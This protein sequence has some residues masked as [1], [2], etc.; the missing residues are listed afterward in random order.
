MV[1][2][3]PALR[4]VRRHAVATPVL[5][6]VEG[7]L[8]W[9]RFRGFRS[10]ELAAAPA[11]GTGARA[12]CRV[13]TGIRFRP[14][15]EPGLTVDY[16]LRVNLAHS[17]WSR[18]VSITWPPARTTAATR[19]EL[20]VAVNNA[21]GAGADSIF[22][23]IG[24]S[25]ERLDIGTGSGMSYVRAAV[26]NGMHVLP[27]FTAGEGGSLEGLTPTEVASDIASLVP[28]LTRLG[29]ATLEFGNEVYRFMDARSY[30]A[31]YDAAHRVVAGRIKLLAPATTGWYEHARGGKGSWFSDL[32]AALP[33]G[34]G[35]VD[36]L[37]LHPYGPM[38]SRCGDGYGW[39]MIGPLHAESVRAGFS[40]SLPW[41]ITEVGQE[42]W[43]SPLECQS[44][45]SQAVQAA[46][47][48]AYLN[49]VVTQDPWVVFLA[50]YTSRDDPTSGFGLLN[51]DNSPRPAFLALDQWMASHAGQT[52]G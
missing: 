39:P 13:V 36:G 10:Y 2:E 50:F 27:V 32:A 29:I 48:T 1:A 24:V 5:R 17:M 14:R 11:R 31:L 45:V 7:V 8:S 9:T 42:V 40:A 6:V 41:Y 20:H 38:T 28:Q 47:V 15:P 30:A 35:E 49:D 3:R 51:L 46:D 22:H 12:S 4:R 44:P 26:G 18:D 34:A 21:F 23:Q 16:R 37:T 19:P 52:A 25:W 43:G 33:G